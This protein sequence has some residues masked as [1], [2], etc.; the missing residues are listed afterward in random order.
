MKK[1]LLEILPLIL[2]TLVIALLLND[3]IYIIDNVY[4]Y[5]VIHND[6]R[7]YFFRFITTF[8]NYLFIVIISLLI[9]VF[10][11][12]KKNLLKL[13]ILTLSATLINN[14][15]KIIFTRSRPNIPHLVIE[16]SYSFPSGH[17][18]VSAIF[19]GYIIYLVWKSNF[20]KNLKIILTTLLSAL[21]ILIGYSRIY[22][23]V[24]YVSDVIAGFLCSMILLNIFLK[25]QK[26]IRKK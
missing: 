16:N 4:N 25:I 23:N 1:F 10:Y 11:H 9:L 24:H 8:G 2:L 5:I 7:T 6:F 12:P 19:Y 17:A 26:Y 18:M 22:L 20:T 21:I 14:I 13:Y 15:L 3:K